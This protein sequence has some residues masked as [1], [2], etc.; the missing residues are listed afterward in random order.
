MVRLLLRCG[1]LLLV[2][3]GA[4]TSL[5][6]SA[7]PPHRLAISLFAL[8]RDPQSVADTQGVDTVAI[9]LVATLAWLVLGWLL[10]ALV[11]V[12]AAA[13]PGRTGDLAATLSRVL[14][15]LATRRVLAAALGATLLTGITSGTATA[16]PGP[17]APPPTAIG[18]LD[19]DWPS[20]SAASPTESSAAPS[21]P[22]PAP[23]ADSTPSPTASAAPVTPGGD[24]GPSGPAE[25]V[26]PAGSPGGADDTEVVVQRGD[27]LWSIAARHLGSSAT[28]DQISHEWPRWW[29]ANQQ[30][31][32]RDPDLIKPGQRLTPPPTER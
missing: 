15:P 32:G 20:R 12:A 4:V 10:I 31:V 26:P 2:T 9:T 24:A 19:L 23:R 14:V 3:A 13:A 7:P 30:I 8:V 28:E 25:V 21:V 18:A 27:T 1:G 22:T 5:N 17:G 11:L 16:A 6:V 29:S